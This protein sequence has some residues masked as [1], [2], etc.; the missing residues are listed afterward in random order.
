[1]AMACA[2]GAASGSALAQVDC[3]FP[4]FYPAGAIC[5]GGPNDGRPCYVLDAGDNF[6]CPG[7]TCIPSPG[8]GR[9][10]WYHAGTGA[11]GIPVD[12]PQAMVTAVAEHLWDGSAACGRCARVTGPLGT[13]VVEITDQCP[14]STNPDWCGG[15]AAHLDLSDAAFAAVADSGRGVVY[16][17]WEIVECPVSGNASLLDA[18]S[19]PWWF[20]AIALSTRQGVTGLEV[21]DSSAGASWVPATREFWNAFVVQSSTPMVLPYDVRLTSVS[22]EVLAADDVVTDLIFASQYDLGAQFEPCTL[23]SDDFESGGLSAWSTVVP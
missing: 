10:T 23:F 18:G 4:V 3:G 17:E 19:N 5:S 20:A 13:V 1:M 9:A 15:D 8:G 7:G 2:M 16:V 14:A 22:G 21:R 12:D 6:G 11:C